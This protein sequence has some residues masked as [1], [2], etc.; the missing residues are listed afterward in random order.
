MFIMILMFGSCK[1]SS[2]IGLRS[3]NETKINA[4]TNCPEDG[5]CAFETI[6][7]SSMTI[8]TDGI[9]ALYP[10]FHESNALILKFEYKKDELPN[11]EDDGYSELIYLEIN[12]DQL[13]LELK[14]SE[15]D[16]VKLLYARLCYCKGLTGYYKITNGHL[17]ITKKKN[18]EYHLE[19]SFQTNEVPQIINHISETFVIK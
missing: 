12:K 1:T 13:E 11:L 19:L 16:E 10:Q 18:E 17:S 8:M 2:D 15:L 4:T 3:N 14:N 5:S 7:N 9:G 6:P